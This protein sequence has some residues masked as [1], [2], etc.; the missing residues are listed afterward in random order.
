M[1]DVIFAE[2]LGK[3]FRRQVDRPRRISELFVRGWRRRRPPERFWGLR[4]V[5]FRLGA[6]R[7]L[8]VIGRNGAGKSTLLRLVGGV[9]R[10]TEGRIETRGRIRAL[11][12][13]G[14]NF[15]PD[16]TGRENIFLGGVVAG[17]T[18]REVK[19][20]FD[21]IVEFAELAPFVDNP[22]RTYSSGMQMRLAFSIAAHTDP[23][24][25]LVDEVLAVGDLA[26]QQKCL[27]RIRTFKE[28]GCAILLV[29]HEMGV[30]EEICDEV[31]LLRSGRVAGFGEPEKVLEQYMDELGMETVRRMPRDR[32]P[33]LA[34]SGRVLRLNENRFGSLELEILA[35]RIANARGKQ[36]E[37][38]DSGEAVSIEMEYQSPLPIAT[39]HFSVS[40]INQEGVVFFDATTELDGQFLG[41]VQ[42]KG[43]IGIQIERLD[44]AGGLY[45]VDVG[46]YERGWT[47]AYDQHCRVYPLRVRPGRSGRGVLY[48]PHRWFVGE[49]P[50]TAA[51]ASKSEAI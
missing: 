10:P 6:G 5:S 45:Y 15:Q 17:L 36:I 9:G 27:E 30:V 46:V 31:L 24:I 13:L 28:K 50:A 42:G 43:R 7:M 49:Q 2:H 12:D 47:Y 22:V 11:L 51:G 21:T 19:Q 8:G 18:R 1:V 34:S 33:M 29:S 41:E 25:L 26:F 4:D 14:S 37:E 3:R 23:E 40:I 20:R 16:M 39:P 32:P 38:I 48:V 35:V 44:L